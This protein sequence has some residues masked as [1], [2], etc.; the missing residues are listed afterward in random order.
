MKNN[1]Y[2]M[3][4]I[5]GLFML[6]LGILFDDFTSYILFFMGFEILETNPLYQSF[7]LVVMV[8][9]SWII[10]LFI[11]ITWN[12][13]VRMY[14]KFYERKYVFYKLYDIFVFLFCI[15]IAYICISKIMIGMYNIDIMNEYSA[16]EGKLKW[17][18]YLLDLEQ[19]KELDSEMYK[20]SMTEYYDTSRMM[21]YGEFIF[22]ILVGYMLF[23]VGHRVSPWDLD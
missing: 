21:G 10:Y 9:S 13:I 15:M 19:Q 12:Y 23:R 22:I 18:N 7:G 8:I 1:K 17:D 3:I 14:H 5:W 16:E 2:P 20:T 6:G 4:F 11:G